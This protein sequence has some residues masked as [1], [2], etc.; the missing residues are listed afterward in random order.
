MK[1]LKS[2][3]ILSEELIRKILTLSDA[4][5]RIFNFLG[6]G[7]SYKEIAAIK[8]MQRSLKTIECQIAN[9]KRKLE[10]PRQHK[11]YTIAAKFSVYIM[12]N[13]LK[14]KTT[15]GPRRFFTT[16]IL[17]ADNSRQSP[18]PTNVA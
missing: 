17:T 15:L 7:F 2:Q 10:E 3:P 6:A 4:E 8:G 13:N 11:L 12:I 9:I 14:V 18:Q 1:P 5:Y 16:K